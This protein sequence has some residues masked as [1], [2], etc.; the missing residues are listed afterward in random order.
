MVSIG[1]DCHKQSHTL[2]A[3]DPV[4]RNVAELTVPNR[5]SQYPEVRAWAARLDAERVWGIENSGS[6][7]RGLAQYLVQQDEQVYEVSPHLTG[8]KRRTSVDRQKSDPTDALAIGRVVVQEGQR[9]PRIQPEECSSI[10]GVVVEHRD[11]LVRERTR[12]INQLHAP[13]V[14]LEPAYQ[15][16]LGALTEPAALAACHIYPL[17]PDDPV[18]RMRVQVVQQLATLILSLTKMIQ[19]LATD[20]I[21]PLVE[22]AHTSLLSIQGI[23]HLTAAKLMARVG[24]IAGVTSAAALAHDSGI[25]PVQLAS[26]AS[27]RHRVNGGGD[28]QLNAV[29]HT[30]AVVQKRCNPVA[31][32]YL[33]KKR[34]EGK[35]DKEALRCVMRRLVDIVYAVWK[36]NVPYHPP[37]EQIATI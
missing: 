37:A 34:A 16:R 30:I 26:A 10:L 11:N 3:V 15:E 8:R 6:F 32:A 1:A 25:A 28:R 29:F 19:Q 17:P 9:L 33:A 24:P 31:Q 36:H 7:G 14:H 21:V 22:Q 13:M 12:L 5:P 2:V 35:T 18:A 23:Q 4:G 20:Q 27:M